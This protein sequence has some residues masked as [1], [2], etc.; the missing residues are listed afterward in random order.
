MSTAMR[1]FL[2]ECGRY[3]LNNPATATVWQRFSPQLI[4]TAFEFKYLHWPKHL[5]SHVGRRD[6]LDVGCGMGL[7]AVGFIL[8]GVRSYTGCDPI[9]DLDS[10]VVKNP[11]RGSRREPC[12][13]TPRQLMERFPQLLYVR[14]RLEDLPPERRWD[15]VVLHN[16]TEHL[17]QIAEVFA[18]IAGLLRPGGLL[19]FNHHNFYA[20]NGHHRQ[21]KSVAA[22]DPQNPQ[23]RKVVD[24]AHLEPDDELRDYLATRVNRITLDELRSLTAKHYE[25]TEWNEALSNETE[26]RG[27]LTEAIMQRHPTLTRRDFETQSAYCVARLRPTGEQLSP[28]LAR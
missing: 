3:F 24:W 26:G 6:V 13:W 17:Q 5:Q 21:P 28:L 11:R 22:I 4:R 27:R 14:G 23:H 10:D 2:R 7:H 15:L 16:T 18:S 20:W 9:I 1:K 25:I 19:I 12:G 8:S